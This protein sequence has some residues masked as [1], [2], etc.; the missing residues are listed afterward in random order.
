MTLIRSAAGREML[1]P[2]E[3][4]RVLVSLGLARILR[5]VAIIAPYETR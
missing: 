5:E 3:L 1:V 2:C 4:A